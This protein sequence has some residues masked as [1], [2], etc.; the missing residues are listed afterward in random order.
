MTVDLSLSGID[1]TKFLR[2]LPSIYNYRLTGAFN[3]CRRI[4]SYDSLTNTIKVYPNFPVAPDVGPGYTKIV[5]E[6]KPR[7]DPVVES[8]SIWKIIGIVIGVLLLLFIVLY[9]YFYRKKNSD[10]RYIELSIYPNHQS[11]PVA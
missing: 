6:I 8:S 7:V 2:I 11:A 1:N 4:T 3:E 5:K 9:F 10:N